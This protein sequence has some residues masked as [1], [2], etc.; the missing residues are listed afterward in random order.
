[1][2]SKIHS[3][4][5]VPSEMGATQGK[6][7]SSRTSHLPRNSRCSA[8]ASALDRTSTRTCETTANRMVLPS[9]LRKLGSRS[10]AWKFCSPTKL[11]LWPPSEMLVRL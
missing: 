7:M 3:H 2:E 1:M 6:R 5:M 8:M 4:P 9:A 11:K 10:A